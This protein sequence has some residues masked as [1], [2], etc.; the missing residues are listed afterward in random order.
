[1]SPKLASDMNAGSSSTCYAFSSAPRKHGWENFVPDIK[2]GDTDG[3]R[4]SLAMTWTSP[5]CVCHLRSEAVDG[6]SVSP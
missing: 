5:D 3:F 2:I 6:R 4:G 1:M